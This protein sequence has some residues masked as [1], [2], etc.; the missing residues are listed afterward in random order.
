MT[1]RKSSLVALM[2][3]FAVC[4]CNRSGLVHVKGRVTWKGEPVPSTLI[5][6]VP[7]SGARPSTAVT[8]DDGNFTLRYGRD[9]QGA[10]PGGYRVVL[11][12][13]VS[14]EEEL[15]QIPPKASKQLKAVIAQYHKPDNSD[16]H[17]EVT[18]DGD[19]FEIELK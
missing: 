19:Y 17:Y 3:V 9:K 7:D 8:D 11:Q 14:N 5:K 16:F 1:T 12:Y 13:V 2:L 6:F 4:G 10:I 18:Q 15:G